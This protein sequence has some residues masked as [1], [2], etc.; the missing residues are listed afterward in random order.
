MYPWPK[1]KK[2]KR[3]PI[4]IYCL[5]PWSWWFQKLLID[6]SSD[7]DSDFTNANPAKI[8]YSNRFFTVR[9]FAK[10]RENV[11]VFLAEQSKMACPDMF[12][13]VLKLNLTSEFQWNH[14]LAVRWFLERHWHVLKINWPWKLDSA[15]LEFRFEI[16]MRNMCRNCTRSFRPKNF[17]FS[18]YIYPSP[19]NF[20]SRSK[21]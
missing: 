19:Q 21:Q 5:S 10:L 11:E 18:F 12:Y 4:V 7:P 15:N 14:F 3:L 13:I 9:W 2:P 17:I 8:T 1:W 16:R 20:K 6:F